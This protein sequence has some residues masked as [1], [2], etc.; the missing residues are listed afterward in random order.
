MGRQKN[1][2]VNLPH[3]AFVE[4]IQKGKRV[5]SGIHFDV[6]C[7]K[8]ILLVIYMQSTISSRHAV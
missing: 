3:A 2:Y 6:F 5:S 1:G 8:F 4:S 7:K